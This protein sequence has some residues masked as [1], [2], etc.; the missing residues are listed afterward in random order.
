L[1]LLKVLTPKLTTAGS[2]NRSMKLGT[3][4]VDSDI[5]AESC[6]A[7][8]CASFEFVDDEEEGETTEQEQHQ[9]SQ[10]PSLIVQ[11][12]T[13]QISPGFEQPDVVRRSEDFLLNLKNQVKKSEHENATDDERRNDKVGGMLFF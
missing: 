9:R 6:V 3:T 4:A 13:N 5:M 2:S 8:S 7:E 11:T 10:P 1:H 12:P